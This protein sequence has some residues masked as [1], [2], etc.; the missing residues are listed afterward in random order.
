MKTIKE[1]KEIEAFLIESENAPYKGTWLEKKPLTKH[2]KLQIR[3]LA[4][5]LYGWHMKSQ[6]QKQSSFTDTELRFIFECIGH[7]VGTPHMTGDLI[8]NKILKLLENVPVES[9]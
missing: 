5:K 1:I 4:A 2:K 3:W 7:V 8:R 9:K 6:L